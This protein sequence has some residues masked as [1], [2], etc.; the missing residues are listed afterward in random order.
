[1]SLTAAEFVPFVASSYF[2][3]FGQT[4]SS[5]PFK[6]FEN[7]VAA[8]LAQAQ[9]AGV[10]SGTGIL[11]PDAVRRQAEDAAALA[12]LPQRAL[13]TGLG[14]CFLYPGWGS[15]AA[16]L[17]L[18]GMALAMQQRVDMH[19]SRVVGPIRISWAGAILL[20]LNIAGLVAAFISE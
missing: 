18:V 10:V 14:F 7:E 12:G 6:R 20:V 13:L 15:T 1:M 16:M 4:F 2:V 17:A 3:L 8:D 11:Y 9:K 19:H 5:E